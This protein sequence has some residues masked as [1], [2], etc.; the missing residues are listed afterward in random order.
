M[1]SI[2]LQ[3][4][5]PSH[6]RGFL[7]NGGVPCMEWLTTYQIGTNKHT[8]MSDQYNTI[9]HTSLYLVV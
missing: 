5:H 2:V 3:P 6:V 7:L 4:G 8:L 9:I 1:L